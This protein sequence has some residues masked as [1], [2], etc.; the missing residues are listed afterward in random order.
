MKKSLVF[1][2]LALASPGLA[3]DSLNCRMVGSCSTDYARSVVVAGGYAYVT[4]GGRWCGLR[5]INISDPRNPKEVGSFRTPNLAHDVAV[6]GDRAY[7]VT[8]AGRLHVIDVS[9]PRSPVE[10]G[11]LNLASGPS[12]GVAV[13]DDCAYVTTGFGGLHVVEV[14]DPRHPAEVGRCPMPTIAVG[15]AVAHGLAYVADLFEGLR[16]VDVSAPRDPH[17]IGHCSLPDEG[18]GYDVALQGSHAYVAADMGGLRVIDVSDPRNP[19]EVGCYAPGYGYVLGVAVSGSHAH[20]PIAY[21]S[22]WDVVDVSNP[23]NPT[24][25]GYYLLGIPGPRG[26]TVAGT[27]TYLAATADGL[28]IAEFYGADVTESELT[29][30]PTAPRLQ[31][32]PNPARD[33]VWLEG[34]DKAALLTPD[35][36][37]AAT[38]RRGRNDIRSLP[39]GIYFVRVAGFDSPLA[40]V[41]LSH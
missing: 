30:K 4:D 37:R 17:E 32:V 5:I 29:P 23:L 38:L 16:I 13:A 10:T 15:I 2:A 14:S 26:V 21:Y 3:Q 19:Y 36:R 35:G 11:Q 12:Y 8:E 33:R 27:Y 25:C 39:R 22:S 40:K 1:L 34:A 9:N 31:L 7:V 41:I 20:V 28:L 18:Y 24:L 6:T